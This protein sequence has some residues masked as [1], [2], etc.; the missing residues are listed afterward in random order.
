MMGPKTS[1]FIR[2]EYP[3]SMETLY[4]LIEILK[5]PKLFTQ[6]IDALKGYI[7]KANQSIETLGKAEQLD[8]LLED[9]KVKQ[10]KIDEILTSAQD[11]A[12]QIVEEAKTEA[13]RV[14]E[15]AT[16]KADEITKNTASMNEKAKDNLLKSETAKTEY[17]KLLLENQAR[18]VELNKK[19][20]KLKTLEDDINRKKQLLAQL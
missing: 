3:H 5:D 14:I 20:A 10:G 6:Q 15:S 4:G 8:N 12:N 19:E 9:A 18:E 17:S 16:Q 2:P 7:D 11:Q 1:N 13:K